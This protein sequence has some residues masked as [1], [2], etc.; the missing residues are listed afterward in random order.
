MGQLVVHRGGAGLPTTPAN[1]YVAA[2]GSD[3]NDGLTTST[4]KLEMSAAL[5][6]IPSTNKT[7]CTIHVASGTHTPTAVN[8]AK[9][10]FGKK[11]V[12]GATL[13]IRGYFNATPNSF[14]NVAVDSGTSS[15]G[16]TNNF[17]INSTP[18][19][20]FSYFYD[21]SKALTPSARVGMFLKLTGGT[22]YVAV[23]FDN[24]A[25]WYVIL[26]NT[27][28]RYSIVGNWYSTTPDAT[29]TYEVYDPAGC[30]NITS[31]GT[32]YSVNFSS[33]ERVLIEGVK[34]LPADTYQVYGS[35]S[36][37]AALYYCTFTGAYTRYDQSMDITY[38]TCALI[39]PST[40][41][42]AI[43]LRDYSTMQF[44]NS[45]VTGYRGR[46]LH[47]YNAKAA[48][49]GSYIATTI[50][51]GAGDGDPNLGI[52]L[53]AHCWVSVQR[54]Y[55]A[56]HNTTSYVSY[57]V[58]AL[59]GAMLQSD[60]GAYYNCPAAGTNK[61]L[62]ITQTSTLECLT[63]PQLVSGANVGIYIGSLSH[64]FAIITP[65]YSSCTINE[66]IEV[67]ADRSV[68]LE[69]KE[70][71]LNP[72][73]YSQVWDD[74]MSGSTTTLN[75][76]QMGWALVTGSG[77]TCALIASE[78]NHPGMIRLST[79]ATSGG[80]V[81]II[82]YGSATL[83]PILPADYFD[84]QL[85]CRI[86]TNDTNA[87]FRFGMMNNPTSDPGADGIYFEKLYADTSWYG[88]T[89][90]GASQ[91]RTAALAATSTAWVTLRLRRVN[92]T[93]VGFSINGG[94]EVTATATIPTVTLI[95]VTQVKNNTTADKT[96]DLDYFDSLMR[97]SR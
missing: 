3:S 28:T 79:S 83:G 34:F 20:D 66:I 59:D 44:L 22:G 11:F 63:A 45:L 95:P 81:L 62:M 25:N 49:V 90:S 85:I 75:I 56:G 86:N 8:S 33:C 16:N 65:T 27:A 9:W 91:T 30:P 10:Y 67:S 21:T 6:L 54:S 40:A 69:E 39:M 71:L 43:L 7:S 26:D 60:V 94:T 53:D 87:Q 51:S 77:G 38:R 37:D 84:M 52:Y 58:L 76:G 17:P 13:T 93:T 14:T 55:I 78:A 64:F 41:D 46:G 73:M 89:R 92:S 15:G 47:F 61:A 68:A 5:A 1:L 96:L 97:L 32:A 88:V 80:N 70:R 50:T 36:R 12:E 82:L 42:K 24:V 48:I 35:G 18:T 57:A 72:K 29:T 31:T 19:A 74:F 23:P 4:P 2:N